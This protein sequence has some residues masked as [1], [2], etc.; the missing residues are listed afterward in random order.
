MATI[1]GFKRQ[2]EQLYGNEGEGIMVIVSEEV[3]KTS[4]VILDLNRDQLLYGRDT[5]GNELTPGYLSDPYFK[6]FEQART[7]FYMKFSMLQDHESMKSYT[8]VQLFPKKDY[9]TP[10]LIVNGNFFY[11]YFFITVSL[12]NYTIGS[13]GKAASDI[14]QKYGKVY[15]LAP[16]SRQFYYDNWIRPMIWLNI[17]KHLSKK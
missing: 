12:D 10:N 2:F 17:L 15:G 16:Q 8:K 14:E 7:Y 4:D 1:A 11:N 3:N 9:N 13:S 6:T 5:A